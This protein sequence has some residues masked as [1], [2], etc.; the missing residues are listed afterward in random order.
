M[1]KFARQSSGHRLGAVLVLSVLATSITS[2]A[3]T[4]TLPD[5]YPGAVGLQK[6]R[7]QGPAQA[8]QRVGPMLH[9][10]ANEYTAHASRAPGQPFKSSNPYLRIS[11]GK[12]LVDATARASG[13]VLL[14]ELKGVGLEQGSRYDNIVSGYLPLAAVKRASG[15][16][17][18]SHLA[19]SIPMTNAGSVTSQ[20]DIAMRADVAR[21]DNSLDGSGVT[22][23]ILSDSYDQNFGAAADIDSGDLPAS[24]NLIDDNGICSDG[25]SLLPCSD[26]GRAMAQIV[27][28]V[29]PGA[30]LSFH[31]AFNGIADFASGIEELADAG[32]DVIVDDVFYVAEPMFQDGAI[33]KAVDNVAANGVAYFSAAGNSGRDSYQ[34]AFSGSG[35]ILY[36]DLGYGFP[37]T[38]GEMHD[39]DPHPGVVDTYQRITI[40]EGQC[41]LLAIQ[42]DSPFGSGELGTGT[43]N[44]LDIFLANADLTQIVTFDG[45]ENIP[46][47]A[48][49]EAI[50]WCNDGLLHP[51]QPYFHFIV[52][53]WAGAPPGLMKYVTFGAAT[54]DEH[55]THS[56]TVYGHAN[57]AGAE[58]VG[59]AYYENTPE[60]ASEDPPS[61]PLIES[62]SSAGGVP[63]L[64]DDVGATLPAPVVR[65]KPGIVAPDGV[66][67][68]FF[69]A[70]TDRDGNG[71]PDFSGTSAAAPHAAGVAALM[72]ES[73]PTAT[74][75][76]IV[77]AMR[78]TAIDMDIGGFDYDTGFG[79]LQADA[80]VTALVPTGGGNVDPV[81]SFS[82]VVSDLGVAF[83]DASFDSDGGSVVAW[84]WSFGDG[85]TSAEQSPSHT[86]ASADTYT[87][88]LT[89]TDNQDGTDTSVQG[90]TVTTPPDSGNSPPNAHFSYSC[91]STTCSFTDMSTD[92]DGVDDI[93]AT[94]WN[95][96]DGSPGTEE[97]PAEHQY[98]SQGNYTVTLTVRDAVGEAHSASASFR[99][100]NRGGTS[101]T[102]GT[103]ADGGGGE[104]PVTI[105]AE[106]G[107]KKCSDGKDNDND[108]FIDGDDSDC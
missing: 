72:L 1:S 104:D 14:N 9:R 8:L 47:G 79:L 25:I 42:W 49:V 67:T 62:F 66:D 43:Q 70:S 55:P 15:L 83:T 11:R 21:A 56:G 73:E 32:A 75:E 18:L 12:I 81:S 85:N 107:R 99:V 35:E 23:G 19:A 38:V 95:F 68:T 63:I 46:D 92:P 17:S 53:L 105:E 74:P 40:P 5:G 97:S 65:L 10:A 84:S 6:S 30:S 91:T 61:P 88:S 50:Q 59:A 27:Y 90:V 22:V 52:A 87:V 86:Y 93:V 20:G 108:G 89:V 71:T 51:V 80:A 3:A 94:V 36:L 2:N 34:H 31:T 103:A 45:H 37:I 57:A 101:G 7:G 60:F 29:A 48:P 77:T 26:E 24:V 39:F 28:D 13:A 16:D 33:A 98:A 58:A 76:D 4:L 106:R 100:K 96:G 44:D 54:I 78:S 102:G 69:H 64:M 41:M 82:Y